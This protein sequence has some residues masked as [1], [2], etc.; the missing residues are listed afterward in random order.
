[1]EQLTTSG[2]GQKAIG[3]SISPP[4]R[5]PKY[6]FE[7]EK[8]DCNPSTD[9]FFMKTHK[10]ASSTIQ[11]IL[12]RYGLRYG[13]RIGMPVKGFKS[14]LLG[15]EFEICCISPLMLAEQMRDPRRY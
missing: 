3:E 5:H 14:H 13:L 4:A 7:D 8:L 15:S 6:L 12:F 9:I 11:N 10:T 2:V 1:M